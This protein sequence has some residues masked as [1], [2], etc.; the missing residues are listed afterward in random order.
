MRQFLFDWDLIR[1]VVTFAIAVYI[2]FYLLF[3]HL[4]FSVCYLLWKVNRAPVVDVI[5]EDVIMVHMTREEQAALV[6]GLLHFCQSE[7]IDHGNFDQLVD[8]VYD[9]KFCDGIVQVLQ[10]FMDKSRFKG[11]GMKLEKGFLKQSSCCDILL[12]RLQAE[13]LSRN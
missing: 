9:L 7:D 5:M 1:I 2:N 4:F 6:L 8:K 3:V 13:T 11:F 12:E 10:D